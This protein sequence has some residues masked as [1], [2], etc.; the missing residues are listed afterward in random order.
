VFNE[1]WIQELIIKNPILL[2]VHEID[3]VYDGIIPIGR[4]I[5]TPVGQ[6]IICLSIL[7]YD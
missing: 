5:N 2:P 1:V 7:M 3:K 6:K 4:E